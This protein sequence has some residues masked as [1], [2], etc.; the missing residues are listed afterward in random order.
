VS[1][2]GSVVDATEPKHQ[3][4]S[5]AVANHQRIVYG[6]GPTAFDL[7]FRQAA[8]SWSGRFD[9]NGDPI[10]TS[11]WVNNHKADGSE[12]TEADRGAEQSL[13]APDCRALSG[14]HD[15]G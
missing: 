4:Y 5:V 2:P 12:V 14:P 11:P 7:V 6:S 1:D 10:R 15:F 13:Q 8:I 9:I 3:T